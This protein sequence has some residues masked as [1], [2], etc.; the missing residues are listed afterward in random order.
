MFGSLVVSL[1][2]QFAG[3][4]LIARHGKEVVTH[5][6]SDNPKMAFQW[7]AF[8]SDGEHEI[9]PVTEG[10]RVTLTYIVYLRGYQPSPINIGA[11]PFCANLKAALQHPH[12]LGFVC[13]HGYMFMESQ[14]RQR[15]S[16]LIILYTTS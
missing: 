10:C 4:A 6:W 14:V 13:K 8:Y 2:T 3:G 16:F 7:A 12:F 5:D 1:P 11:S 9:L 15:R